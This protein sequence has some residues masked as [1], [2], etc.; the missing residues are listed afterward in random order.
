M[1][2][3]SPVLL[4]D[5]GNILALYDN[6]KAD[7]ELCKLVGCTAEQVND[8]I[9]R[10]NEA[11]LALFSRFM[12]G[13]F[14]G[15]E[16]MNRFLAEV[17]CDRYLD[18]WFFDRAFGDVFTRNESVYQLWWVLKR[19]GA[20]IA[21]ISNMDPLRY[22]YIKQLGIPGLFDHATLSY[23]YQLLKPGEEIFIR[24]LDVMGV[25]AEDAV[26]ID[27]KKANT[28]AAE[29]LGIPS[30]LY[31]FRNRPV[32]NVLLYHFLVEHGFPLEPG[33]LEAINRLCV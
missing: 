13:D 29:A 17:G 11:D 24:T 6:D 15:L 28:D 4:T 26:F 32:A 14:D 5:I 30:F 31:D 20:E 22:E 2:R 1:A 33:D 8:I 3:L 18:Y 10:K 23:E 7:R 25:K 12:R 19:R 27:D 21:A 9:F 16:F